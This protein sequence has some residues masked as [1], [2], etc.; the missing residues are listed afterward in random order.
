VTGPCLAGFY[1]TGGAPSPTP[2]DGLVG[3]RCPQGAYC[4]LGSASPLPCPPGQYSSSAGNTGIQ[5]C[6]LCDAGDVQ[7]NIH[8][9]ARP[10]ECPAG[11][12][13]PPGTR[14][15]NQYPCP[16]GTYSRQPGLANPRD[17]RPCPGGTF[18]ARAGLSAPSGLC[19]PGHFC[20]SQARV[21]DPVDHRHCPAG[22]YC[23]EGSEFPIPCSP[24]SFSPASGKG[25]AADCQLCPAGH[26]CS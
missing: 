15:A 22:S 17:C 13:C 9:V 24:G 7:E 11:H 20:T 16:E 10:L 26:S 4:P 2:S 23:P 5:D 14:A 3:N 18:C 19:W 21:P 1:C 25:Q 8:G 12:Y 6:L